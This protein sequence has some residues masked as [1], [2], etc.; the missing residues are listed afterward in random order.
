M[1]FKWHV[2]TK[3]FLYKIA[4]SLKKKTSEYW[5]FQKRPV[6]VRHPV[7]I[8]TDRQTWRSEWAPFDICEN[9]PKIYQKKSNSQ[10]R[11]GFRYF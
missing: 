2:S 7:R 8:Q 9:V 4:F 3:I 1:Q 10:A 5:S 11:L 6:P